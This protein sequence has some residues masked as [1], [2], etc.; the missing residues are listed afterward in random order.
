[1]SGVAC[2]AVVSID[3][4]AEAEAE[5]WRVKRQPVPVEQE[6]Q[7]TVPPE[8][9]SFSEAPLTPFKARR[10]PSRPPDEEGAK[11]GVGRPGVAPTCS[12]G[13]V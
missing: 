8:A 9:W 7:T 3:V 13:H 5:A 10:C 12:Q 2:Q 4:L 6:V 1:M 11:P